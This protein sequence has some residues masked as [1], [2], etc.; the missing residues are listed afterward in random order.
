MEGL[1]LED[2]I[3]DALIRV[4]D[5]GPNMVVETRVELSVKYLNEGRD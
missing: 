3:L 1:N 4:I 5:L 2:V